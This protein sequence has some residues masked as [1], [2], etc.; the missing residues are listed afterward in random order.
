MTTLDIGCGWLKGHTRRG[1]IGIDIQKGLCDVQC[2]GQLLPFRDGVFDKVLLHA[3]LEHLD[4]PLKCLKEAARVSK[5]NAKF[6]IGIPVDPRGYYKSLRGM[7]LG[8]PFGV[9]SA[10]RM[11]IRARKYSEVRGCLHVNCIQPTDIEIVLKIIKIRKVSSVEAGHPWF[12]GRKGKFLRKYM[13]P[14]DIAVWRAWRIIAVKK[15]YA[16]AFKPAETSMF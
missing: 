12:W 15:D 16:R 3:V 10:I 4:N 14:P 9:L 13:K 11:K 1:D 2:D 7:I 6:V 8:F 5:A